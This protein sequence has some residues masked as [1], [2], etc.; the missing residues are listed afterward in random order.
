M[1]FTLILLSVL[2]LVASATSQETLKRSYV[3]DRTGDDVWILEDTNCDLDYNDPGEATRFF[4]SAV[5]GSL[6]DNCSAI[7]VG[8]DGALYVSAVNTDVIVRLEDIDGDGTAHGAG[9]AVIVFDNT[10]ASGITLYSAFGLAFGPGG[11]LYLAHA[12]AGAG[13]IDAIFQL[14]D[15]NMDGDY[16]DAAEAK[17]YYAP[18]GVPSTGDSLPGDLH[19]GLDGALYYLD[20]GS[21]GVIAKGIYRLDDADNNGTINPATEVAPFFLP[22]I[23]AGGSNQFFWGFDQGADGTFY[24]AD[25]LNE[26]VYSFRDADGSNSIDAAETNV[27]W[28]AG[29]SS[30]IWKVVV[31]DTGKIYCTED[32]TPDRLL[33]LKDDDG[34]GTITLAETRTIY[35]DTVAPL[36]I[37]SPRSI[38]TVDVPAAYAGNGSDIA[39]LVDINFTPSEATSNIHC[40]AETDVITFNFESPGTSLNGSPLLV[41]VQPFVTGSPALPIQLDPMDPGPSLYLDLASPIGVLLNGFSPPTA[42]NPFTPIVGGLSL[43]VVLPPGIGGLNISLILEMFA[44]DPGLN[45]VGIGNAPSTEIRIL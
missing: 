1:R 38:A 35:D 14:T 37:S 9:E 11:D 45:L 10:N 15:G 39:T 21:T 5:G 27:L 7:V 20:V 17:V 28:S 31:D 19:W 2:A 26:R 13:G 32:Q 40:V 36:G 33:A 30:N 6:L 12:N 18:V 25:T 44:L 8:P 34:N 43:P 22:T 4:D 42:Q 16:L 41:L 23:P 24:M 3:C 29:G